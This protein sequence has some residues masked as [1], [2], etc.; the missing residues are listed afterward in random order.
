METYDIPDPKSKEFSRATNNNT[1][2][3]LRRQG[4]GSAITASHKTLK[5][6]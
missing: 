1:G 4:S 2:I 5:N 6:L 3:N